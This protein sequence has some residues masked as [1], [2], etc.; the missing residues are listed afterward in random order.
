M[1]PSMTV[2]VLA[3]MFLTLPSYAR[4]EMLLQVSDGQQPTDTGSDQKI[5]SLVECNE[6]GGQALKVEFPTEDCFGDR[7]A[8]VS[9]WTVF[10]S[11]RFNAFN[12]SAKKI[13]L[14]LTVKH[15]FTTSYA[16]RVD[17][18]ITLAP[19]RN[20]VK[21]PIAEMENT[22][23]TPPDL[24]NVKRWYIAS[25]VK[26]PVP[27]YFGDIYLESDDT[28]SAATHTASRAA[29]AVASLP[30]SPAKQAYRVQGHIGNQLVDLV[31]TPEPMPTETGA[32]PSVA[33]TPL[34]QSSASITTTPPLTSGIM[35]DT[36]EADTILNRLQVFPPDNPWNQD[37]SGWPLH[38][39]SAAIITSIGTERPLRYNDDMAFVLVPPNQKR[40]PVRID[41]YPNESD[42]GPY[43]V[44]D[45]TPIEGWP[46]HFQGMSLDDAQRNTR[47]EDSDRH[48]IVVDPTNRKLYEF[49]Q[50]RKTN[51]GWVATQASI[52]DL[53]TNKLRPRGWTS[54]DAAG[55]PIFPAVVRY[56]ELK[57]G[58]INHAL[59]VTVRRTCRAFVEP[60]THFASRLD[61]PNLPR[62]GERIR[63]RQDFN[64]SSFSREV[65]VILNAL[66]KYGM[67]VADNGIDWAISVA[68][69][70]RIPMLH[71][72]LRRIHGNAFE[73]VVAPPQN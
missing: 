58:F 16:N 51:A 54:A 12:P 31:V 5:Y 48:G 4:Q 42:R 35:F 38:S 11:V 57:N 8:K 29:T 61:D 71:E 9:N 27:L 68:P 56:D 30:A 60:A 17:V 6:L 28:Q 37:I 20:E 72:E 66:K 2:V 73:V 43:P 49:Y 65:Q 1:K 15:Q 64:V 55:L 62:M 53:T 69:D 41:G 22:N 24:A 34:P 21:L 32:P 14:L 23:H 46:K 19:G 26:V 70:R 7:V 13:E 67:F 52:F 47:G 59:R 45:N 39:N 3:A 18:P 63:L 10:Q 44:P 40:V 36:P 25:A 33:I 50:L